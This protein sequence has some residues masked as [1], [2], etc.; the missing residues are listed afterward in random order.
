MLMRCFSTRSGRSWQLTIGGNLST[1][2]GGNRVI[3]YGMTRDL[4]IGVEAVLADGTVID[5][6]HK[7]RKN[8]T[9]MI[10]SSCSL[11][12]KARWV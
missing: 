4:V 11:A 12:A 7:L 8:N 1:N 2:A 5:G 3:R 9:G 10:S 6:L